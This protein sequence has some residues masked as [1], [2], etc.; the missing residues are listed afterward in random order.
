MDPENHKCSFAIMFSLAKEIKR[1][2]PIGMV[3]GVFFGVMIEYLRQQEILKR[4]KGKNALEKKLGLNGLQLNYDPRGEHCCEYDEDEEKISLINL[5]MGS[6]GKYF[7]NLSLKTDSEYG[8]DE[9][10]LMLRGSID[11]LAKF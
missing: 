4:P 3:L 1:S 10:S 7:D 8:E 9:E 2:E 11:F 5:P 6:K